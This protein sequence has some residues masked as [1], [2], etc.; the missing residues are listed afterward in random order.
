MNNDLDSNYLY[1]SSVNSYITIEDNH[2]NEEIPKTLGDLMVSKID[3]LFIGF[4]PLKYSF[5]FLHRFMNYFEEYRHK[6]PIFVEKDSCMPIY[7]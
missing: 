5:D 3:H 6:F 2:N 4:E 7:F 1:E